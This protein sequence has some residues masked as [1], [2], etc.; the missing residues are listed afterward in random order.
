MCGGLHV[1]ICLIY[2]LY[3]DVIKNVF[4]FCSFLFSYNADLGNSFRVVWDTSILR[5]IVYF[6]NKVLLYE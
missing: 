2:I 6:E 5:R 4:I 1:D 3:L